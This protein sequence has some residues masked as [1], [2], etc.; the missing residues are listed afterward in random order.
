MRESALV[1]HGR[2]DGD[3]YIDF[4]FAAAL[5]TGRVP[6]IGEPEKASELVWAS[7]VALPGDVIPVVRHGI[8]ALVRGETYTEYGW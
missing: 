7:V 6:V 3:T 2:A 4:F 1:Q 8:E 5:P